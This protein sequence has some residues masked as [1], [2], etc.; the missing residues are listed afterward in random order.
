[1]SYERSTIAIQTGTS[2]GTRRA[3][4]LV[5]GCGKEKQMRFLMAIILQVGLAGTL[6]IGSTQV[7]DK[8][9]EVDFRVRRIA[10]GSSYSTVLRNFG[11]PLSVEREKITDETC[12]PAH[13]SLRLTYKGLTTELVWGYSRQRLYGS[14][15]RGWFP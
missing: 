11:K 15:N 2:S 9:N 14:V 6:S 12:G 8:L 1:V 4:L 10:L 7:P 13:T 3:A 5:G